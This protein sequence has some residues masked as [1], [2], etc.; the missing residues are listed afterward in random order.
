LIIHF[1]RPQNGVAMLNLADLFKGLRDNPSEYW[2]LLFMVFSTIIP[3][4]LHLL[5]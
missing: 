3:T 4:I 2:W 5:L 1:I